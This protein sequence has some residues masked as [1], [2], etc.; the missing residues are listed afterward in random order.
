[1]S[2][3]ILQEI[4]D[5]KNE[6]EGGTSLS[7]SWYSLFRRA[8]Q[9]MLGQ[10]YPDTLK[11]RQT[12]YGGL[13]NGSYAYYCPAD[14]LIPSEIYMNDNK[15]KYTFVP[16]Q[17]FYIDKKNNTFTLEY[18][19]GVRFLVAQA[20]IVEASATL[21]EMETLTG[22]TSAVTLSLNNHNKLFGDYSIQGTFT[23]VNNSITG[24]ITATDIT[25]YLLGIARLGVS[26][27]NAKNVTNVELR[28]ISSSGNYYSMSTTTDST[29]G[30]LIDGWNMLR[31]D[32]NNK[33]SVGTPVST[34]ITSWQLV[35]TLSADTAILIDRLLTQKTE[36]TYFEYISNRLF[37]DKT[38]AQ[39]KET[40]EDDADIIN[41]DRDAQGVFHYEI[42]RIVGR[43]PIA[44]LDF[45]AEL[46][47]E[48]SQYQTTHPSSAQALTYSIASGISL[49]GETSSEREVTWN[50]VL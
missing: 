49:S 15:R 44:G 4:S 33:T 27:S 19:N 28:L 26:L 48:I 36:Q 23:S 18:L 25:S 40:P 21:D 9:R 32:M 31:F 2:Y 42:C 30:Y 45:N 39:W 34:A 13:V 22:K 29:G 10:I 16:P 14:V 24:T 12:I 8:S 7:V 47:M 1:M 43:K 3:L 41:L 46:E 17:K 11:R 5:V 37:I 35:F 6:F 50:E 20:S 38:T